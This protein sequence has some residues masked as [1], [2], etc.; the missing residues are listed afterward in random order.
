MAEH[1]VDAVVREMFKAAHYAIY[2]HPL[3][4][5][6]RAALQRYYA[7]NR[8]TWCDKYQLISS[9]E[10][11]DPIF[12]LA[13]VDSKDLDVYVR[14][15]EQR[16]RAEQDAKM[17]ATQAKMEQ[18][19]AAAAARQAVPAPSPAWMPS[20][21]QSSTKQ[22][23][24]K[25]PSDRSFRIAGG[26]ERHGLR[27]APFV[28]DEHVTTLLAAAKHTSQRQAAPPTK[29]SSDATRTKDPSSSRTPALL[30]AST[31]TAAG[32]APESPAPVIAA[33]SA[34]FRR[35]EHRL[36][37]APNELPPRPSPLTLK[38]DAW[39]SVLDSLGL[40]ARYADV[41]QGLREGFDFEILRIIRTV[42]A[43]NA[44]S[45]ITYRQALSE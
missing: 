35:M 15:E 13:V 2:H 3:A 34:A 32:F 9:T 17:A 7:W 40:G 26:P 5:S 8:K 43:N 19:M 6:Q 24:T 44:P 18:M 20:P 30:S 45:A 38:A 23:R 11:G 10:S 4:E 27:P 12:D 29:S 1:G 39:A 21:S 36:A 33:L 31:S 14:E 25:T 22:R 41:V 16:A 37:G 28:V 42:V